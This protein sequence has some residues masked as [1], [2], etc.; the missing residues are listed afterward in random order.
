MWQGWQA[1][2]D[3]GGSLGLGFDL[4]VVKLLHL[5]E[6]AVDAF[7]ESRSVSVHHFYGRTPSSSLMA[8][9]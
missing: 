7:D 8:N 1:Y 9:L 5:D 2:A 3:L 6:R 4:N